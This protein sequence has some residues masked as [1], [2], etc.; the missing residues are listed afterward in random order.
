MTNS[1][2]VACASPTSACAPA[3]RLKSA[4]TNRSVRDYL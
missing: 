4:L 2:F 1:Y 3:T